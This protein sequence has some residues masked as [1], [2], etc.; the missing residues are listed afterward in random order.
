MDVLDFH[1]RLPPVELKTRGCGWRCKGPLTNDFCIKCLERSI[2]SDDAS[3][4]ATTRDCL[5][6]SGF[7]SLLVCIYCICTRSIS[8]NFN[9]DLENNTC[10]WRHSLSSEHHRNISYLFHRTS[11]RQS[12]N[13]FTAFSH[14]SIMVLKPHLI[15]VDTW[16]CH[17][18]Y[19]FIG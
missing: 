5:K 3:H 11:S 16:C 4:P 8:N 19:R 10:R 14:Q 12:F 13:Q 2:C 17:K 18:W 15:L 9:L 1:I 7:N 6:P